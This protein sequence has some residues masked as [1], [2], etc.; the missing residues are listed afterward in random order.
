M[1][2]LIKEDLFHIIKKRRFILFAAIAILGVLATA[3]ITKNKYW[4]DLTYYFAVQDYV[5][6]FFNSIIGFALIISVYR[7]EYTKS[8]IIQVENH[9]VKRSSGVISRTIS[10]SVILIACYALLAMLIL[11]TGLVLGAHLSSSQT[12]EI[13]LRL[14][15][16]C[17][18]CIAAYIAAQFWLYLFAF[19][20]APVIVYECLMFGFPLIFKFSKCY[21][22]I[23]FKIIS[24]VS[25]KA[26]I[27]TLLT[28]VLLSYF[29]AQSFLVLLI[30]IIVPF[31]FTLLI[32]KFK[33]KEK[34]KRKTKKKSLENEPAVSS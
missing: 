10:S 25:P 18:A 33:K 34:V 12:G 2:G 19:P 3:V 15:F 21:A 14:S 4:N 28:N 22:I 24:F 7:R 1:I 9:G 8:S 6:Y 13:I 29:N 27:D 32:F 30:Q 17:L 11:V 20:I 31:L 23:L 16:D 5:F 26:L